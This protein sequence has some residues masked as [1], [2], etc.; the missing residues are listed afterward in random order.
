MEEDKENLEKQVNFDETFD[1]ADADVDDDVDV[2][3][4]ADVDDNVDAKQVKQL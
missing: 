4:D 1:A 2:D 3:A